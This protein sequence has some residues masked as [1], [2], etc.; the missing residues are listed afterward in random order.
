M[1][2]NF[3]LIDWA[4]WVCKNWANYLVT[5][6]VLKYTLSI[7]HTSAIHTCH[8]SKLLVKFTFCWRRDIVSLL[9]STCLGMVISACHQNW[10]RLHRSV[11]YSTIH[12]LLHSTSWKFLQV[13]KWKSLNI[14]AIST[15]IMIIF[16]QAYYLSNQNSQTYKKRIRTT[17]INHAHKNILLW[18][19]HFYDFNLKWVTVCQLPKREM[20]PTQ[21]NNFSHPHTVGFW[22]IWVGVNSE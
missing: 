5:N 14:I 8:D 18:T 19:K 22:A 15:G 3:G 4:S 6:S 1:Y 20:L 17:H 11:F 7:L 9:P 10:G 21:A 16:M 12:T 2:N 13:M